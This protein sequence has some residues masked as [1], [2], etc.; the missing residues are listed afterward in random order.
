MAVSMKRNYFY[1]L[2]YQVLA[3]VIPFVTTPYVSRVLGAQGIG[4]YSYTYGIV[5]YFG[6]FAMTGT[7]TYGLREI[8][9]RQDSPIDKNKKFWEIFLFRLI[10]TAL[11]TVVYIIFFINFMPE[12]RLLY[13]INLLTV[14]SWAIDVSWYLQGMENFKAT[15]LR[16]SL[17]K[18]LGTILIF[19]LIRTDEDVWLYTLIYCGTTALG[20]LS[21]WPYVI[22]EVK[23]PKVKLVAVFSNF[24]PIMA[25]FLPVVAMQIYTVL[26]KTMLGSLYDVESVGY[27][28]QAD[29]VI[30][31]VLVVLSSLMTVLLPRIALMFSEGRSDEV[32][33]YF[34][35]AIDY[36][37]M[38]ALPC[39]VMCFGIAGDFVP[40]F[41]GSGYEP[42][43]Q[44]M[45]ILC[46][47]FIILN[48][49]QMFGNFLVASNNENKYTTG[50]VAAAI[51]NFMLNLLLIPSHGSLGAAVATLI[52][53][54][55]STSL[56][57]YYAR[58]LVDLSYVARA[59]VRYAIPS[60]LMGVSIALLGQLDLPSILHMI[61]SVATGILVY[62]AYL[63]WR[64]EIPPTR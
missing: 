42:V 31:M 33:R 64:G 9:K 39:I 10:C 63:L 7:A 35:K 59:F 34:R 6:I 46:P 22:K 16:N 5:S 19:A 44:L 15:A 4:D 50:V 45:W 25:L 12:Y 51:I 3:V 17:V 57:A 2:A 11:V 61:T 49:G 58:R 48:L 52:A 8:S 43:I 36:S 32:N 40:L 30:Q 38:L 18:V 56:Q 62:G 20:N 1:N 24:R 21:M 29:K 14:F 60:A 27:Y 55:A 54:T 47:L 23:R 37:L 28:T 53:E 13:I 41:F 26:N